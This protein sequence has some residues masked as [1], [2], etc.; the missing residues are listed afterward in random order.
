MNLSVH[1]NDEGRRTWTRNWASEETGPPGWAH[2]S[3]VGPLPAAP[4]PPAN[5][6]LPFLPKFP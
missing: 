3:I 2:V 5:P 6:L 1:D 4:A